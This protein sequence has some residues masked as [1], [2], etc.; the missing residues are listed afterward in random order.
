M[1][2]RLS[3]ICWVTLIAG[4]A[5]LT[6]RPLLAAGA[7]TI[8][9]TVVMAAV[10]DDPQRHLNAMKPLAEYVGSKLAKLGIENVDILIA[11]NRDQLV[12]LLRDGRVDWVTE[13]AY[14]AAVLEETG[15]AEILL[16]KWK[17]GVA[18][19][20]SMLFVHRDSAIA[21]ATGLQGKKLA[22]QHPGSTTGYFVPRS[23][24]EKNG[25]RMVELR[26]VRHTP[27]PEAVNYIFSGSEYNSALWVHK[28]L[29]DAAVLSNLD[30]QNETLVPT[31]VKSDLRVLYTSAPI[32]R[33]LEMVRSSLDPRIKAAIREALLNAAADPD[34]S[35]ALTAYHGTLKF[36]EL[37][38]ASIDVLAQIRDSLNSRR[39]AREP[40][41]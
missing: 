29:V 21:S 1:F 7:D 5:L 14:S 10:G 31:V 32:P 18:S 24:L 38:R 13:T 33:A 2:N 27:L 36:D 3:T 19:Y 28:G 39:I 25:F 30:W 22:F 40:A 20:H 16:R 4:L 34:A 8:R 41:P 35:A 37:D 17:H 12:R 23:E 15:A 26:S 6:T 11:Q 9:D